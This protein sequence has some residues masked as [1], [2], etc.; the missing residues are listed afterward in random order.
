VVTLGNQKDYIL[1]SLDKPSTA[2]EM[3]AATATWA[4]FQNDE[5]RTQPPVIRWG[6]GVPFAL[7]LL[8][9]DK[10]G[11]EVRRQFRVSHGYSMAWSWGF[12]SL[13]T[14]PLYMT[15]VNSIQYKGAA[16]V[17]LAIAY[18]SVFLTMVSTSTVARCTRTSDNSDGDDGPRADAE[19]R[20]RKAAGVVDMLVAQYVL[21]LLLL[22][23]GS[24]WWQNQN[25]NH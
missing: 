5:T 22:T 24:V 4:A 12:F 19:R 3:E 10:D 18:F 9:W 23:C 20:E 16:G 17:G 15:I 13:V 2:E 14:A 8:L 25:Q 21:M 7:S 11:E 6:S 1:F